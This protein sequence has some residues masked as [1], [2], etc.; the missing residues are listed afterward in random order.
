MYHEAYRNCRAVPTVK[1]GDIGVTV[2]Y[3]MSYRGTD[4]LRKHLAEINVI[5]LITC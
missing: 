5:I 2:W 3:V 1:F 4:F